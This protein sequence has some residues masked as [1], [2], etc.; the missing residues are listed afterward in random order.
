MFE[1]F[2]AINDFLQTR[3]V[4]AIIASLICVGYWFLRVRILHI[5]ADFSMTESGLLLIGSCLVAYVFVEYQKA[6]HKK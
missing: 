5:T 2:S 1:F 6:K 3:L 4:G